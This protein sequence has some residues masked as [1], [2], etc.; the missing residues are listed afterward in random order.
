MI[1]N[2]LICVTILFLSATSNH[3][4]ANRC[5]AA[6]EF[7]R[8]AKKLDKTKQE[9]LN[10]LAN[11]FKSGAKGQTAQCVDALFVSFR[12]FYY[13]SLRRNEI[14][15]TVQDVDKVNS[16]LKQVGWK[17]HQSEGD[18]YV[19]EDGSWLLKEFGKY[20]SPSW[21]GYLTRREIEIEE[22]LFEDA[23]LMIS[24]EDLRER[25]TFWESFRSKNPEFP[26]IKEISVD[27]SMYVKIMLTGIDN[28]SVESDSILKKE[29][30]AVYER[31][32]TQNKDSRYHTVVKGYY[33][34]LK[35]NGFRLNSE[36]AR[37]LKRNK[38]GS[39]FDNQP[40]G[41]LQ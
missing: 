24:W 1:R 25:T 13:E 18:Y 6:E 29:V 7:S 32:L 40:P 17:L 33:E 27:I 22:G 8:A 36:S 23:A 14:P 41:N 30:R 35:K 4:R 5:D 12:T 11:V 26:L 38:I 20:L 34:I 39:M 9:S 3:A 15:A 2:A 16:K 31:F 37:F 21:L 28:T 10:V 19:G